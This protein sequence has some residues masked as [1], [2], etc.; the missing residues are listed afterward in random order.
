MT[1]EE[2]IEL[3]TKL[4]A[5]DRDE[6][7]KIFP[8]SIH[9]IYLQENLCN[10]NFSSLAESL[11]MKMFGWKTHNTKHQ[12]DGYRGESYET[13]TE[14]IECKPE[15]THLKSKSKLNGHANWND[16]TLKKVEQLNANNLTL[17][18]S[19]WIDG[20]LMYV[21]TLPHN[22]SV[23]ISKLTEQVN[24][25]LI[26]HKPRIVGNVISNSWINCP[27]LKIEWLNKE[28]IWLKYKEKYHKK[29]YNDLK[30]AKN[31]IKIPF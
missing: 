11:P 14:Y 26:N 28:E 7:Y 4:F 25:A 27:D 6:F 22:Y 1:R 9:E 16:I 31:Q 24:S 19:G 18:F 21:A 23:L 15:K 30:N 17:M 20:H 29:F 2:E 5:T 10:P 3:A 8:N 12:Y 13:A